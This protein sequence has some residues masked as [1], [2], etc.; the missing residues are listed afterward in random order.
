MGITS[1]WFLWILVFI[2]VSIV[3]L[4]LQKRKQVFRHYGIAS[5]LALL[6]LLIWNLNVMVNSEEEYRLPLWVLVDTSESFR[7]LL[8]YSAEPTKNPALLIPV[9]IQEKIEAEFPKR[10]LKYLN[11]FD[12]QNKDS[13]LRCKSLVQGLYCLSS[14]SR[15]L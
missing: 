14:H 13:F 10:E 5:R 8:Q 4:I 15:S 7:Q 11:W 9:V 1:F 3:G 6:A 2:L 12:P